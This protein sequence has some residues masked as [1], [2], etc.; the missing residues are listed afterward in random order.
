MIKIEKVDKYFNKHKKNQ[1]HVIND[2]TLNFNKNGL[3]ALLGPSGSGKTTLLNVIGGLDKVNRGDIYINGEKITKRF[4][5]KV[6][7]IRNLNVG[8]IFQDYYLID[9][10]SVYDNVAIV[11]KMIGIKNKEEIKARVD[12]VLEKLGIYRYRRRLAGMLSGGERQRVGIAR[13]IVKNPPIIIADEPTGNLDSKNTIEIMN[14][15]KAISRDKLVVLV[16]HEKELAYFYSSRII[17]LSDGKII[18]DKENKIED[19][20][21][22]RMDNKIYLKE[23]EKHDNIKNKN[24]NINYYHDNNDILDV[25]IVIRNG[26]IYLKNNTKDKIEV[27]NNDSSIEF[28]DDYYK[29][30]SKEDYE[31]YEFHLEKFINSKFKYR[32]SSILNPITTIT[33]GFKKV[34]SYPI[35]KKLLLLGFLISGMFILYSISNIFGTLSV[36][37]EKFVTQNKDYL[38]ITKNNIKVNDYLSYEKL[39]KIKYLLPGDSL[40]TFTIKYNDYYQTNQV[41]D[42][43]SGSLSSINMIT[44]K[45]LIYGSMPTNN[46]EIVVDKLSISK[47]YDYNIAKQAG[48]I[49]IDDMLNR[50]VNISNMKDFKI[51]GIVDKKSPSIYVNESLFINIIANNLNYGNPI[52]DTY[53]MGVAKEDKMME[54]NNTNLFDYMIKKDEVKLKKGRYP[55]WDYE[56]IVN[57][58]NKDLMPLNKK[59]S[60]KVNGV[61][62]KVVG[63]YQNNDVNYLL[64]NNNTIKYELIT[65]KDNIIVYPE[66]KEDAINLFREKGLNIEDIYNKNKKDYLKN[67]KESM[68]ITL[69]IAGIILAI[70]FVEIFLIIRAS[71]LSRI[72]EVGI[73]RAIGVKKRDI[74]KM[75]LGEIIAITTIGSLPG[76]LFM[77]Y[78]INTLDKIKYLEDF[79]LL[80]FKV[81]SI[82]IILIYTFNIIVGLI[83]VGN[84]IKNTPHQI[85]SRTD[86]D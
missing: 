20:L 4:S 86:V 65:T 40:V 76:Y 14:I 71:F 48:L 46:Y 54:N 55:K 37:D 66:N 80:D 29:K 56:V 27:I 12:Y 62:L 50:I 83:P 6:D 82:S 77:A 16:T 34:F 68:T 52:F 17:E 73:L 69:V 31:K 70:S 3:V 57:I 39:D 30:I 42:N 25:D 9:N 36:G 75:F 1:I 61:K 84:V 10:M 45:D 63:Y 26:N 79:Y 53:N 44:A 35:L 60:T 24:Y 13:A 47:M 72:K 11:L 8:Y 18:S 7:E 33:N 38:I 58:N 59:I 2:T 43:L 81:L 51:V 22:Y 78:I 41:T 67:M 15:I 85:L 23:L 28:I 64:V 5:S 32:Y 74:Y 49:E 19:D 21:D